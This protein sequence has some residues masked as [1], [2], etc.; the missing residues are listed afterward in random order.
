MLIQENID[1]EWLIYIDYDTDA[2]YYFRLLKGEHYLWFNCYFY[3]FYYGGETFISD[4]D[5]LDAIV[6]NTFDIRNFKYL[7]KNIFYKEN[8]NKD[9]YFFLYQF[10][11]IYKNRYNLNYNLKL[12][13]KDTYSILNNSDKLNKL[14][15]LKKNILYKKIKKND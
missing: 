12:L 13:N 1:E 11:N 4:I 10:N 8:Y 5:C 7:Y 2:N 6:Y 15:V 3:F 14:K 9:N